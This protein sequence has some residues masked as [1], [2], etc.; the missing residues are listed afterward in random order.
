M[1]IIWADRLGEAL[2]LYEGGAVLAVIGGSL[3]VLSHILSLRE[4]RKR[5]CCP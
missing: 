3:L 1:K 4:T 5:A 2:S